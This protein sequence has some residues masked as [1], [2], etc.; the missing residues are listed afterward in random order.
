[1]NRTKHIKVEAFSLIELSVVLVILSVVLGG[2]ITLFNQYSTT[3]KIELTKERMR[4]ILQAIDDYYDAFYN[5]TDTYN[6]ARIPAPADRDQRIRITDDANTI[7]VG[8]LGNASAFGISSGREG[9]PFVCNTGTKRG[10]VPTYT[11]R[12]PP[13]YAFDAWGNRILY[14]CN[15]NGVDVRNYGNNGH[16][17]STGTIVAALISTGPNQKNARMGRNANQRDGDNMNNREVQNKDYNYVT[18]SLTHRGYD[19]ITMFITLEQIKAGNITN[20][21]FEKK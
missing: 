1:L 19:D 21:Y 8:D 14:M 20:P 5:S 18:N 7:S 11:L 16:G 17:T 10:F 9:N 12:I 3:Q 4:V 13:E 15:L 2:G 6:H